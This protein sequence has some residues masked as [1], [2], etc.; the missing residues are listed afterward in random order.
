MEGLRRGERLSILGGLST[1]GIESF[2]GCALYIVSYLGL[3]S[4]T[5]R[6]F[7]PVFVLFD[8]DRMEMYVP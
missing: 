5:V 2:T 8:F 4:C 3:S 6:K 1:K 7:L